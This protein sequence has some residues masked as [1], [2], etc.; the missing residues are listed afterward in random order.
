MELLHVC[1]KEIL[2]SDS[3][4][5]SFTPL[6]FT[7][8]TTSRRARALLAI[9]DVVVLSYVA[10]STIFTWLFLPQL[11]RLLF[12]THTKNGT[13]IL[14]LTKSEGD[15]FHFPLLSSSEGLLIET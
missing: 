7:K 11:L 8:R 9:V 10:P 3:K 1:Y 4:I 12:W 13:S 2:K 5:T 14:N 15:P 6:I